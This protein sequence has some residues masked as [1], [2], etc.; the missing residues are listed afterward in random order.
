MFQIMKSKFSNQ[1]IAVI[2]EPNTRIGAQ[3]YSLNDND[4]EILGS[5]GDE[6]R[7]KITLNANEFRK[8]SSFDAWAWSPVS[9]VD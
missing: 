9:R 6:I 5:W 4:Y 8:D 1:I 2:R 7:L 3:V